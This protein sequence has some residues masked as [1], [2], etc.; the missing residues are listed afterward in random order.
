MNTKSKKLSFFVTENCVVFVKY[1]KG[2][3]VSMIRGCDE[4]MINRHV[5]FVR[6]LLTVVDKTDKNSS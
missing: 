5:S 2:T 1:I 6:H 4:D 3:E